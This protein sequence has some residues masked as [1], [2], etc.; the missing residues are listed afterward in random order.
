MDKEVK[1]QSINVCYISI[2]AKKGSSISSAIH[3]SILLSL[4]ENR[5]VRLTFNGTEYWVRPNDIVEMVY[6]QNIID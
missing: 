5:K 6:E 4:S 1:L 3:D 2:D